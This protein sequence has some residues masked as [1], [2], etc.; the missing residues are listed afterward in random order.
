MSGF[1]KKPWERD[2]AVQHPH[3]VVTGPV[4]ILWDE[5][6]LTYRRASTLRGRYMIRWLK[7]TF[8]SWK[9][10]FRRS[11]YLLPEQRQDRLQTR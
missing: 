9:S 11:R 1:D 3:S 2:P 8:Q 5:V 10:V 4:P 6:H 7:Q